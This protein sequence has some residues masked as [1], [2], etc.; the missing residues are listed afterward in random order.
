MLQSNTA[1]ATLTEVSG[2]ARNVIKFG[3]MGLIVI[4]LIPVAWRIGVQI[5]L[6]IYPPPPPPPTVRY[7]KLPAINFPPQPELPTPEYTLETITGGLPTLSGQAKVYIVGVNKSRLLTLDRIK[8]RL[9]D[10]GFVSEPTQLDEQRYRFTLDKPYFISLVADV[11]T[12]NINYNYDWTKDEQ[13]KNSRGAPIANGAISSAK[14]LLGE[15]TDLPEEFVNNGRAEVSYLVA[16]G[17]ATLVPTANA[18][19]ANFTRVDL[20]RA[21]IDK[22][23]VVT[24][25]GVTSPIYV[26]LS[27]A[28]DSRRMVLANY[29]YSSI[30]TDDFATY[31]LKGVQ[32]AWEELIAG[33]AFIANRPPVTKVTVREIALAYYESEQ[34]QKFLQTVYMFKGDNNFMAYV[35]AISDELLVK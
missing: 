3:I 7:G 10:P 11:I 24:A 34:A 23:K 15:I 1:M 25:G 8:L 21:D 32:A 6:S 31:P 30:L 33:K 2:V 5:Y 28:S 27:S 4:M 18:Y 35:P 29:Q 17:S 20:F 14:K 12:G 19:E 13:L 16:T 26:I 22:I 9:K